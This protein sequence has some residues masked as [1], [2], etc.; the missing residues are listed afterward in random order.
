[1][2]LVAMIYLL[3][4]LSLYICLNRTMNSIS[5]IALRYWA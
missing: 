2:L 5:L 3:I 1:M 4:I